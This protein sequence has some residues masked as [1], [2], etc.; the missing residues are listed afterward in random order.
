[1][2]TYNKRKVICSIS[3]FLT[4]V[5]LF[6]QSA[7]SFPPVPP[8]PGP[9]YPGGERGMSHGVVEGEGPFYPEQIDR[10]EEEGKR[11]NKPK[12]KKKQKEQRAEEKRFRKEEKRSSQKKKYSGKRNRSKTVVPRVPY[13][14]VMPRI[15]VD[16]IEIHVGGVPYY[17]S[18]GTYYQR[19]QSNYKVV[20][21]PTGAVIS[22]LPEYDYSTVNVN[23][24]TYFIYNGTYY[25]RVDSGYMVVPTPVTYSETPPAPL[26]CSGKIYITSRVL[27]VRS[28]PG[29][30]YPIIGKLYRGNVLDI[31][32][33][34]REWYY[35]QL[36][37]GQFGWI[38]SR[39]TA[40]VTSQSADG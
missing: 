22:M 37:N 30:G 16:R 35:I 24:T 19:R 33:Y 40:P 23:G 15:P 9:Q 38:H 17:F 28:S 27:N 12:K 2:K 25:A 34:A 3:F 7:M 21:A 1:M 10:M 32:G 20:Q 29:Q 39:F 4:I 14:T 13:G 8:P 6:S 31:Q 18:D 26:L 11:Y 36:P 5:F